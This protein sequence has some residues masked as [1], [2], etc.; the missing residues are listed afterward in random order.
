MA[1]FG[2]IP[3]YLKLLRLGIVRK[4]YVNTSHPEEYKGYIPK[5]YSNKLQEYDNIF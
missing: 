5:I 3:R 1:C 4:V 2:E